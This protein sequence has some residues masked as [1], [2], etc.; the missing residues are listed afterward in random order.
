MGCLVEVGGN[1]TPESSICPNRS[2]AD[3][4]R[5]FASDIENILLEALNYDGND[6]CDCVDGFAT[7]PRASFFAGRWHSPA[8]PA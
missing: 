3:L 7:K 4:D 5:L 2:V 8:G 6:S 1:A